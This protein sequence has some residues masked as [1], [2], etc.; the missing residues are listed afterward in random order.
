MTR[1]AR[2]SNQPRNPERAAKT[3]KL[4]PHIEIESGANVWPH[5][6][7][8]A[9]ALV[10][11]GKSVRFARKDE[12]DF[13]SSPDVLIDGFLWELKAPNGAN[14]KAVERNVRKAAHQSPYIVFDSRRMRQV[15]DA[16]IERELHACCN[17]RVKGIERLIF[18]TRHADMLDIK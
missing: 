8:T 14:I 10:A 18:I 2:Y 16:A 12:R 11:A 5:G 6:T 17:G 1:R 15:P 9:Q 13:T 7:K 3:P 4:A